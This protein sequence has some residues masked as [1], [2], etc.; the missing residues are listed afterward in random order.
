MVVPCLR[1]GDNVLGARGS[2]LRF[3]RLDTCRDIVNTDD[4]EVALCSD[5]GKRLSHLSLHFVVV[6]NFEPTVKNL[7]L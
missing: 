6:L 7:V 3:V 4:D 5:V 2:V 1:V